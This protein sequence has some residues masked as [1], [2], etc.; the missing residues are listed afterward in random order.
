MDHKEFEDLIS[1]YCF[2]CLP[3]KKKREFEEHFIGCNKCYEKLLLQEI[4]MDDLKLYGVEGI[5]KKAEEAL[6]Y[7]EKAEKETEIKK[8]FLEE[9]KE[10]A[11]TFIKKYYPKE[12]SLFDMAWRVFKDIAPTDIGREAFS[13]GLGFSGEEKV[14]LF[15]PEVIIILT[16]LGKEHPGRITEERIVQRIAELGN[17]IRTSKDLINNLT[18]YVLKLFKNH[19]Q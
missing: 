15:T 5:S 9:I 7:I 16:T 4:I 11:L 19:S 12:L 10:I 14:K 13:E 6:K 18:Q 17:Q 8:P 3:V 2:D 1:K